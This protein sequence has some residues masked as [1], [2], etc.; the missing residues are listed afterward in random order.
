M[1]GFNLH[2]GFGQLCGQFNSV[3]Q[4]VVNSNDMG[5]AAQNTAY[6][7]QRTADT[8]RH[9]ADGVTSGDIN[10]TVDSAQSVFTTIFGR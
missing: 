4:A 10:R 9:G 6:D 1:G 2:G 8:V 7:A 3:C 5:R